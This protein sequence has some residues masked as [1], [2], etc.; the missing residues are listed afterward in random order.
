[1]NIKPLVCGLVGL[2][3]AILGSCN[4]DLGSV[5]VSIQPGDDRITVYFDTLQIDMSTVAMEAVYARTDSGLLGEL[6]DPLYGT[7]KSDYISQ[8]Y[9]PENFQFR[10]EPKDGVIDSIDFTVHYL[11]WVGDSL[12]PMRA[13]VFMVNQPL[14]N[15]YYTNVDPT[16]YVD[17]NNSL[18]GRSYT[19]RDLAD[20]TWSE[21]YLYSL[22][23]MLPQELG[24]SFYDETINN[25]AS[26]SNQDAFNEFFPG[27]YVTNTFGTGSILNVRNTLMNIYYSRIVEGSQGQDST[28]FAVEQFN[29]TREVIQLNRFEN[30]DMSNLLADNEE[31]TYLKTPA[32]VATRIVLPTRKLGELA[33]NRILNNLPFTLHTMPQENWKYALAP[34]TSLLLIPEDSVKTFFENGQIPN[35]RTSYVV[36]MTS[37]TSNYVYPN[38]ANMLS[39]QMEKAPD[40]DLVLMAIPVTVTSTNDY[41][42]NS[43]V[44][45]V[46]H[47]LA[48][49]GVTL[50]K[51]EEV[52]EIVM[53]S[54]SY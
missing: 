1:M 4:D 11:N 5:G 23:I 49:S 28:V 32:G 26:F 3:L 22:R 17:M 48:P 50:R 2:G 16:Q 36:N 9:C 39:D 24:Q 30:T 41:Y 14:D 20:T 46:N 38:I 27:L 12:A 54:S 18:G 13:E 35:N 25:P 44:S 33:Q 53:T 19:A 15:N 40:K 47:Y 37:E 42:G 7:I 8:F 31:F 21:G 51:D 43:Y 52:R 6:Y 45:A 10:Y 34:P 29:V